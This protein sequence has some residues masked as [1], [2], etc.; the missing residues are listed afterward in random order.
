MSAYWYGPVGQCAI[1]VFALVLAGAA[2]FARA[3]EIQACFSPPLADGCDPTKTVVQALGSAQQQVLVQAYGFI[4]AP[5]AQAL[6]DAERR[7]LDVRVIFDKRAVRRI[8]SGP[9]LLEQAGVVL[10]ID[11]EHAVAHSNIIILDRHTV[12]TGSFNFT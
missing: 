1:A 7:V 3:T 11:A 8:Y 9:T 4:S 10:L 2:G 5:I 6:V 12:I